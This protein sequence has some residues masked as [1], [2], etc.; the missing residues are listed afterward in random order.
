MG[1]EWRSICGGRSE[2]SSCFE[3]EDDDLH[4]EAPVSFAKSALGEALMSPL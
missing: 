4:C 2:E 1:A 3:R